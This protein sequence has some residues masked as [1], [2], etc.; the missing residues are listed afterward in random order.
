M[1]NYKKCKQEIFIWKSTFWKHSESFNSSKNCYLFSTHQQKELRKRGGC[2]RVFN[3][4]L[5]SKRKIDF[6]PES[7]PGW[8]AARS[9]T[10]GRPPTPWELSTSGLRPH[11]SARKLSTTPRW[12]RHRVGLGRWRRGHPFVRPQLR[13]LPFVW[14]V[15][16]LERWR[17]EW[18]EAF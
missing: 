1:I 8:T 17:H 4:L 18:D 11:F 14:T 7:I 5:T 3:G 16:F 10:H 12:W 6:K 15:S 13:S 9:V 2:K